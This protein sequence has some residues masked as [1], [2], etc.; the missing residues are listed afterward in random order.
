[1][2]DVSTVSRRARRA[3]VA[4]AAVAVL[5]AAIASCS[6]GDDEADEAEGDSAGADS[7]A[8]TPD[9]PFA[10]GRRTMTLVDTTRPTDSVPNVLAAEPDR[11]IEVEVVYPAA[12]EPGP[13]PDPTGEPA[14]PGAAVEDA[15]PADGSFPL[16]VFAHG[17]NGGADFFV[18]FAERWAREGYVVALPTFPLSRRGIAV[19]ADLAN[20]PGDVSFVID[21]LTS[22]ADDD[23]LAGHVDGEH[24][25]VGGHSLGGATVFGVAYN[26]CCTDERIDATIPVSG[27]T[28]PFEGG[29]FDW[30]ATPM[31]LVHGAQDEIVPIAIGDAMFDLTRGPVW[32]L[33]PAEADHSGVFLHEPGRLFNEAAIAF[34]DAELKD[35]DAALQAIADEVTDSGIAEWRV[36]PAD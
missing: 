2:L 27:G 33:R 28:L 18:G 23:P 3:L 32:Y 9:G 24:I 5:L 12:G 31:L 14:A 22:L 16:V 29:D 19:V 7:A 11:T 8:A 10:S 13:A 20:Q 21:S 34:L 17:F 1:V 30:P 35:D 4:A 6:S 26:S 15:P 25:A 36:A